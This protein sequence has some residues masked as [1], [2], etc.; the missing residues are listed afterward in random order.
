MQ[1]YVVVFVSLAIL[2]LPL[3]VLEFVGC[4]S[5]WCKGRLEN[6]ETQRASCVRAASGRT[7]ELTGRDYVFAPEVRSRRNDTCGEP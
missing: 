1:G 2:L 4:S 3:S 6:G 7:D 5:T